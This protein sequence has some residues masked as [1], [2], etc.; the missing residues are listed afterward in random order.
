MTLCDP[1]LIRRVRGGRFGGLVS[2]ADT[3]NRARLFRPIFSPHIF[4][5]N[6][7]KPFIEVS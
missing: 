6:P 1:D 4:Y 3:A 2:A 5:R 7:E